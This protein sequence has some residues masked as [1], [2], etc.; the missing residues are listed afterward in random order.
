M[1]GSALQNAMARSEAA[2]KTVS[3]VACVLLAAAATAGA[4]VDCSRARSNAEKMLCSSA[5]AADAEE[6]MALAFRDAMRRGADPAALMD[7]QR[8]WTREVRD[9]CNSIDCLLKAYEDRIDELDER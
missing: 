2:V 6:A 5:R 4:A 8:R 9:A 3:A 7:S 1:R